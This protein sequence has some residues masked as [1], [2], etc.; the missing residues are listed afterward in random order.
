MNRIITSAGINCLLL[1]L[2][3]AP[4]IAGMHDSASGLQR[5]SPGVL[6][7]PCQLFE[8]LHKVNI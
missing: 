6:R 1:P 5:F 4:G 7:V 2:Q 8:Q 3:K